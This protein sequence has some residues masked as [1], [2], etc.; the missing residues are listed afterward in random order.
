M[1]DLAV[2]VHPDGADAWALASV[3]AQNIEVGAPPDA[4]N[5]MGQTWSQP[6][7][8]PDALAD[9]AFVPYRDM[10]RT[11][12]RHA[13]GLRIDHVLGLFRMWWVPEGMPPS[14]GTFVRFDHEAMIGILCL[15]AQGSITDVSLGLPPIARQAFHRFAPR[16]ALA[17]AKQSDAVL[18]GAVGGPRAPG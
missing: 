15:E 16:V 1:H 17:L 14:A 8:R 10:L 3:L 11:V 9:A 2:G 12:L 18:L 13:G 7:W 5:Q 6:P 4:F